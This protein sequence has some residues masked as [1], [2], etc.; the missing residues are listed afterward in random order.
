MGKIN[1]IR[2]RGPWKEGYALD[3]HTLSSAYLG[4]DQCGHAR[5]DTTRSDI[6]QLVYELKYLSDIKKA[7]E[8]LEL[9]APF[10]IKWDI[11]NKIDCI[12]PIPPS[13]KERNFQPVIEISKR[14]SVFLKKPL[15]TN[16]IE[17]NS[18]IQS[19]DL[20]G[21]E[22]DKITDS[23]AKKYTFEIPVSIMLIDD[24]YQTGSTLN[25][26][27]RILKSD[28]NVQNIYVLIMTKTRR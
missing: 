4:V 25:Q 13:K 9:I 14:I 24:L 5:Y 26:I 17:N 16:V 23:M 1:P 3:Y 19:K 28:P 7:D 22:K 27:T 11:S 2:L 8:I 12:I 10:L 15:L 21:D 6:G 18:S 20:A